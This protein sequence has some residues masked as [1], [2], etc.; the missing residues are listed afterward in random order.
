MS[1]AWASMETAYSEHNISILR[2]AG[3]DGMLCTDWMI[4]SSIPWGVKNLTVAERFEKA[5][6]ELHQPAR[7]ISPA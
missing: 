4:T 1:G 7:R 2:N 6:E 3:W 5:H